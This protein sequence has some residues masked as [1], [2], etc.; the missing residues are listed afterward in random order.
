VERFRSEAAFARYAGLAPIPHTSGF[1]KVRLRPTRT[2]N[3][4]LNKALHRITI[5]QVAKGGLGRDF[6][7][8]RIAEGDSRPRALR[9]LKRRLARVV[10]TALKTQAR[11]AALPAPQD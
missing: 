4:Q 3:R 7:Q 6:Y 9:A 8:R 5:T 10:F 11:L 2:G 1:Q